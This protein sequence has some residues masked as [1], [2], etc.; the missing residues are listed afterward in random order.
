MSRVQEG[1]APWTFENG[2][3]K[4]YGP[5]RKVPEIKPVEPQVTQVKKK[6]DAEK[7]RISPA[8]YWDQCLKFKNA[9]TEYISVKKLAMNAIDNQKYHS[10]AHVVEKYYNGDKAQIFEVEAKLRKQLGIKARAFN[11]MC[12]KN[13]IDQSDLDTLIYLLSTIPY[14]GDKFKD[15]IE[16]HIKEGHPPFP[17]EELPARDFKYYHPAWYG[18]EK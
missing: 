7:R 2:D 6:D 17:L 12:L 10:I 8:I 9:I 14:A 4:T 3:G 18:K 11:V 13:D 15:H 16:K 5:R 1:L